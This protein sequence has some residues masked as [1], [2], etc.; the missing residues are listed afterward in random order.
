M[1]EMDMSKEIDRS[2]MNIWNLLRD[3]DPDDVEYVSSNSDLIFT[4]QDLRK[5]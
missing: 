3:A 2:A 5:V 4:V 1:P